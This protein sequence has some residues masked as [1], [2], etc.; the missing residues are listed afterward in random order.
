MHVWGMGPD[1]KAIFMF[2]TKVY[3]SGPMKVLTI[4]W[5]GGQFTA[6]MTPVFD[7]TMLMYG[8]IQG[9]SEFEICGL[10]EWWEHL[11]PTKVKDV[12]QV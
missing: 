3:F 9:C 12:A 4:A 10:P 11:K 7:R 6:D 8:K 2:M 1:E 5:A